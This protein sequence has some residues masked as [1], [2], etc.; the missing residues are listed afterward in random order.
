MT[1]LMSPNHDFE[2]TLSMFA[3]K[4]NTSLSLIFEVVINTAQKIN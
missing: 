2:Q 4:N 3:F 1:A